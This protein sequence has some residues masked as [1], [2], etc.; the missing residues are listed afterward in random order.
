ML[1]PKEYFGALPMTSS[2]VVG[3]VSTDQMSDER[4]RKR[5]LTLLER[6]SADAR[7]SIPAASHGWS[8]TQAAY[9]FF[10]NDSV[11]PTD[12]LSGHREATIKRIGEQ[13]LVLLAQDTTFVDDGIEVR[14]G[15]GSLSRR[16]TNHY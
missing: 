9:R 10:D 12:I 6:L 1:I 13:R 14:I 3:K 11:T 16:P 8:E 2:W 4:L 5:L 7:C 15:R